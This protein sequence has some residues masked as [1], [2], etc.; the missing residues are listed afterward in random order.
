MQHIPEIVAIVLMVVFLIVDIRAIYLAYRARRGNSKQ[1][2]RLH[3]Q[4][5]EFCQL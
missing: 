3:K 2:E 4:V 1:M 5:K